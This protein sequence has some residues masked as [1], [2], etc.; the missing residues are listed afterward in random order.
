M[1]D[2]DSIYEEFVNRFLDLEGVQGIARGS[3]VKDDKIC[4]AIHVVVVFNELDSIPRRYCGVPVVQ[5][6]LSEPT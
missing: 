4:Q 5:Y 1:R 3:Y 2:F 6:V